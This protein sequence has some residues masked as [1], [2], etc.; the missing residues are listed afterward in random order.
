VPAEYKACIF[1]IKER[2]LFTAGAARNFQ[3][4]LYNIPSRTAIKV[5]V[6]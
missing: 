5:A 6:C 4:A 2:V 1:L 3:Y